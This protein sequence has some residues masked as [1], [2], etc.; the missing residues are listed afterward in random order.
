MEAIT[1]SIDAKDRMTCGHSQRVSELTRMLSRAIGFDEESSA[2]HHVAGLVHDVGK[3]GVPETVLSKPG[4]LDDTE[5]D[6]IRQ[7]PEIGHQILRDIPRLDDILPG[8]LHHHERW[9]GK[10]YPHGLS[11]DEIPLIARIIALADSFDAMSCT[12]A[13]RPSLQ[14]HEV[15]EEIRNHAGTQFDPD[16]ADEFLKLDFD[17]FDD[18]IHEQQISEAA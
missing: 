12:R 5:F 9:D 16:L 1:S 2:R 15:L 7:H 11:E 13:Y 6:M 17:Q 18:L 4:R 14:R 8:V 3:I 10:G